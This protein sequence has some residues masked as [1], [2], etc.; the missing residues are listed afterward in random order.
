MRHTFILALVVITF[1]GPAHAQEQPVDTVVVPLGASST[2]I[3]TI[4]DRKDLEVLRHYDFQGLFQDIF[5]R[6]EQEGNLQTDSGGAVR[7]EKAEE[8][9]ISR[10]EN[11]EHEEDDDD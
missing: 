8:W 7:E 10:E 6:L 5:Q 11:D 4:R 9:T 1:L 2:I 3:F